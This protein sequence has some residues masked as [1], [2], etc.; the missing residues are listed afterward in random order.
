MSTEANPVP[1]TGKT[2]QKTG[3]LRQKIFNAVGWL[4]FL[5][6]IPPV[7]S[8]FGINKPEAFITD[9]LGK[10]GSSTALIG[11]FYAILFLRIFFGSDQRYTPILLGYFF[12]FLCFSNALSIGFMSWFYNLLHELPYLSYNA[13]CLV[14]GVLIIFLANALSSIKKA[15]WIL[16]LF[17]LVVL[18]IG[19]LVAAGLYLP[20]LLGLS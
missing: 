15:N 11:Y 2:N 6:L 4:A 5:L 18:P 13:M 19:A 10:W 1:K 20:G 12:S 9:A 7:L 3:G 14:A 16:D 17:L 8:M